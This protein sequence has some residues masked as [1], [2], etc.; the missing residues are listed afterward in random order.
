MIIP[1]M[2]SRFYL[3]YILNKEDYIVE[4]AIITNIDFYHSGRSGSYQSSV[5]YQV[6]DKILTGKIRTDIRDFVGKE[7]TISVNK[8]NYAKIFPNKYVFEKKP[9]FHSIIIGGVTICTI[10]LIV[11]LIRKRK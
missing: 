1:L 2:D 7:I 3:S 9:I 11:D 10:F 5:E 8:N 4:N 6:E